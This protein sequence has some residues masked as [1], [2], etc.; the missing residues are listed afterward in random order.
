MMRVCMVFAVAHT[1]E[2]AKNIASAANTIGRR[3]QMSESFAQ[4]GPDAAFASRKAP[5]IQV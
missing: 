5:P 1:A 3:P 2:L 4:M